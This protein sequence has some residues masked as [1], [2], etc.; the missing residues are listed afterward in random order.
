MRCAYDNLAGL[1]CESWTLWKLNV[2]FLFGQPEENHKCFTMEHFGEQD[3]QQQVKL[4]DPGVRCNLEDAKR[5]VRGYG[6]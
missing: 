3:E 5:D 2:C 4:L 1:R 6:V